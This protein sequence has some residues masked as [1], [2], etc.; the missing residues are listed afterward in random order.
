MRHDKGMKIEP[1]V[2]TRFCASEKLTFA[3]LRRIFFLLLI[4][5]S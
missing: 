3:P 5:E 2:G 4:A 1:P